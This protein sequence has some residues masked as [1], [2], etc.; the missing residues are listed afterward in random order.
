MKVVFTIHDVVSFENTKS[1]DILSKWIYKRAN[2]IITHNKFSKEIFRVHYK[3]INTDIDIIP[4]GNYVPF[5]EVKEDKILSRNYLRIPQE[6]KVLLFFGMIKK[7]K[8]L[9]VLLQA[10]KKVIENNSDVFLV[11]AGRVWKNDFSVYQLSLI[12]I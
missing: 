6:R 10:M 7:V 5:L 11:I 4:H 8:G 2:K 1:T 12:H 9:E 3:N